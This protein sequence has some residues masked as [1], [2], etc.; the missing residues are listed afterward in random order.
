[1]KGSWIRP[2]SRMLATAHS[3]ARSETF[4]EK[5]LR[6]MFTAIQWLNPLVHFV[7]FGI[8]IWAFR[9]CRKKGYLVVAAYFILV[10]FSLLVMPRINRAIA[11]RRHQD[12]DEQIQKEIETEVNEAVDRVLEKHGRSHAGP[13]RLNIMFPFG[14][15]LLVTGLWLIARR[16]EITEG[17]TGIV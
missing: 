9:R 13:L 1:M 5:M 3:R 11:V 12:L 14:P 2:T 8:V 6:Y 15:I 4:G 17:S 10:L 16:E 7:G